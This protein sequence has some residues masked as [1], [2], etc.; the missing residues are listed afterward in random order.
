MATERER[1]GNSC[2]ELDKNRRSKNVM[3][4]IYKFNEFLFHDFFFIFVFSAVNVASA[5]NKTF[6]LAINYCCENVIR[7]DDTFDSL[8]R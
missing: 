5:P 8:A 6:Q 3:R 4:V 2:R 1:Q 7:M